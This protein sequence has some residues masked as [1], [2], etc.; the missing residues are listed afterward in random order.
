M[1]EEY[2]R[3]RDFDRTTEPASG[4]AGG[5]D[6]RFLVQKHAATRLHYDFRLEMHGVLK[7]WPVPKGPSLDP[8]QKRLAV[9]VEDHPLDYATFEGVIGHGNY[10]A[11]QVIVWDAGTYSPDEDGR[12]SFGNRQEAEERMRK[13]LEAGKLSFT[14][15]GRKLRGSWTLV[16][17][18]RGPRDWLLI[19]HRDRH[20]DPERDI[21]EEDRSVQSGLT[22]DDLKAGRLPEPMPADDGETVPGKVEPMMARLVDGPFSHPEWL[23]EPKLDGFRIVASVSGGRVRLRSRGGLDVTDRFPE[24]AEELAAQPESELLLDGELVALDAGGLPSFEL[25]QG[26]AGLHPGPGADRARADAPVV[27]YVFDLLHLGGAS[28]LRTPLSRRKELLDRTL[29]QGES[30][31][32]VEY[33]V[34]EGES[35]FRAVSALGLEGSVAKRLDSVYEPGKRSAS[36][37]KLKRVRSQ[38]MVVGGYT[39]GEGVRSQT[40][41]ALLVGC[42]DDEGL[43]YAGRVGS[44]FDDPTLSDLLGRLRA[45]ES[46]DCPFVAE[47]D[48]DGLEARWVRPEMVAQVRFAQ[49][50]EDGRLRAP[51]FQGLRPDVAPESVRRESPAAVSSLRPVGPRARESDLGDVLERLSRPGEEAMTVWVE[52]CPV[53]LTN[54]GKELWPATAERPAVTKREMVRYYARVG[55][56]LLPHLR[57]RPLTMTRYPNGIHGQSFYQKHYG[58]GRPDFVDTVSLYSSHNEGDGE[59]IVVNNLATIVW[60]AQVANVEFHPWLSRTEREPDAGHLTTDFTGSDERLAGSVLNSPD[61]IVFDLD[62]YLYSGQER[63]GD[64][65]EL[66]RRAFAKTKEV[67]LGDP[68]PAEGDPGPAVPVLLPQDLRQ[69]GA[70]RP[71]IRPRTSPSTPSPGAWRPRATPGPTSSP[72]STTWAACCKGR[73]CRGRTPGVAR[74]RHAHPRAVRG[75]CVPSP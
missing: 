20:A 50:T 18:S 27:Y 71:R 2:E 41:G 43:R 6:L 54:L 58:Q 59:Y 55:P 72:P 30:L 60:L 37:L 33:T 10:G 74:P 65:P 14:L 7:S 5:G 40:F 36:W 57:H 35:F 70:A 8:R 13:G 45:L 62:P 46:P 17:S 51:V 28:L 52:G 29:A 23:F 53:N 3:K 32:K 19:K 69:D 25:L 73:S 56:W 61:Y 31:R 22:I 9:M 44:G 1:L 39:R 64:E 38:E 16:K 24:V 75:A 68:G 26:R 63:P 47:P 34:G 67:A 42:H 66:N 4:R 15:R 11:G 49:W 21:L 12:L 48:L